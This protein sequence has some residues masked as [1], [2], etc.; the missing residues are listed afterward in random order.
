MIISARTEARPPKIVKAFSLCVSRGQHIRVSAFQ[1]LSGRSRRLIPW[2][3][4]TRD[5][6]DNISR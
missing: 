4:H 3:W 2:L 1:I 5:R 6:P